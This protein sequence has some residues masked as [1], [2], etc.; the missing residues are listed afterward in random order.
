[1]SDRCA[2]GER[3]D[4]AGEALAACL[5]AHGY[6]VAVRALVPDEV[7]A[8]AAVLKR[9]AD[10]DRLALI[11]TTGGTGVAPRDVT[12]EATH[13]VVERAVPGMAEAMRAASLQR[14]P[15]AM[16]SRAVVGI[17]GATLIINLPGSPG[18]ALENLAVLLPALPHALD[19]IQGDPSD[20]APVLA[21]DDRP[22]PPDK[23]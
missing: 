20:C 4:L 3:E 1:V 16:I 6:T 13:Q 9:C 14:T 18:G 11:V 23:A 12:P 2:R 17:R 10:D 21:P 22:Q 7:A 5:E 19:K 8:I 15:H